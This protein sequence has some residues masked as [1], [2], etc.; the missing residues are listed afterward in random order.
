MSSHFSVSWVS[1]RF[2]MGMCQRGGR[3]DCSDFRHVDKHASLCPTP[4]MFDCVADG[5]PLFVFA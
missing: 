2:D 3:A 5:I 1:V 4:L